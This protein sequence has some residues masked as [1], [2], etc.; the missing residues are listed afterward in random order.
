MFKTELTEFLGLEYPVIEGGMVW[1][2]GEKLALAVSKEGGLG[3][4]GGASCKADKEL[5]EK[6]NFIRE[7]TSN[8]FAVNIPMIYPHADTLAEICL[9]EKVPIVITSAGNPKKYT[10]TFKDKGIKVIHVVANEKFALKAQDA[11]V[12][13][14]VVEG[15]EAGGHNGQDEITT[16]VS[17][18]NIVRRVNIPVI[19]AGGIA[20]GEQILAMHVLGAQAVQIGTLFASSKESDAHINYK[21]AIIEAK[22][23]STVLTGRRLSPVRA[24]KNEFSNK[25]LSWEYSDLT[26]EEIIKNIGKGGSYKGI[27]EGDVVNGTPLAGQS[28]ALIDSVMSVREIFD[29]L[30]LE[31]DNALKN[32]NYLT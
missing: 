29:K 11:G 9:K 15:V 19:A 6:I 32:L 23:N 2:G 7:N 31:F 16:F 1:A 14:I 28:V 27:I 18:P 22:D 4:I 17:V 13:A 30:K 20:T 24:L 8:P 10:Q 5:L 25:I 12:D 26:N 21:M 3:T